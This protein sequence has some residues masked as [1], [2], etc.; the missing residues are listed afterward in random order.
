MAPEQEAAYALY[1]DLPRD[2]L[3]PV[4][5]IAYDRLRK[6]RETRPPAKAAPVDETEPLAVQDPL[7]RRLAAQGAMFF[8]ICL[9]GL[10]IGPEGDAHH[11]AVLNDLGVV[12][13][14]GGFA[15]CIATLIAALQARHRAR[16]LRKEL[17]GMLSDKDLC[18]PFGRIRRNVARVFTLRS[19]PVTSRLHGTGYLLLS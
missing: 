7:Q 8:F 12:M 14:G 16:K 3:D 17:I 5:Q 15:L 2:G 4:V 11:I 19:E 13:V 6:E 18:H 9:L 1:W 10:V